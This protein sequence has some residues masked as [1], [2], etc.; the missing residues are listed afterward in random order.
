MKQMKETVESTLAPSI[1]IEEISVD[2]LQAPFALFRNGALFSINA[3]CEKLFHSSELMHRVAAHPKLQQTIRETMILKL[4]LTLDL[5]ID[6]HVYHCIATPIE[7]RPND[8][9]VLFEDI[10]MTAQREKDNALLYR[11]SLLFANIDQPLN[12]TLQ[13]IVEQILFEIESFDCSILLFDK[14]EGNLHTVA[15]G[16][17]DQSSSMN[18]EKRFALGEGVAGYVAI[19]KK[20]IVIPNIMQD[21]RFVKKVSDRDPLAL[22]CVPIVLSRELQGVICVTRKTN[23]G[24]SDREVQL[25]TII[26]GRLATL[27]KSAHDKKREAFAYDLSQILGMARNIFDDYP[28]VIETI[29]SIFCV[30]ACVIARCEG[31]GNLSFIRKESELGLTAKQVAI[32]RTLAKKDYFIKALQGRRGFELHTVL[33]A[34]VLERAKAT[35][36]LSTAIFP[37]TVR[38]QVYGF[39]CASNTRWDRTFSTAELSHGTTIATQMSAAIENTI[40]HGEILDER[41]RLQQIQE[42]LRDGLLLYTPDM[43]LAMYNTAAR[44]MLGFKRNVTGLEWSE[45]MNKNSEKYC[46]HLLQR[47]FDPEEFLRAALHDGK[48]STGLATLVG[49]PNRTV[50]VTVAPVYDRHGKISAILSHFRD[51]T[52]IHDLQTKM[53]VRLRQLTNLFKISSVSGFNTQHL[54]SRILELNLK[55]LSVSASELR[56][57]NTDDGSASI[58]ESVGDRALLDVL[59]PQLQRRIKSV[60]ETH[61]PCI[62]TLRRPNEVGVLIVPV[63]GHHDSCIG[64]LLVVNKADQQPFTK[65]DTHMLSIVAARIAS[66]LDTAWLLNQVEE[67]REKLAAIID[68][69]VDGILVTDA[70]GT[71]NIWNDA[72]EKMTGLSMNEVSGKPIEEVRTYFAIDQTLAAADGFSEILITHRKTGAKVW[73]GAAYAPIKSDD[74]LT[75][76]VVILRDIS[77]QK[78]LEIAKN[79]FVSTASHELR[80]PIT[81]IVGYLSMLRRGDAGKIINAQQAFFVDKAYS[82]A[83]RMVGIIEDILLTT[84]M[85]TGQM[86][87]HIEPVD[88]VSSIETIVGDLRFRAEEK[89]ISVVIDRSSRPMALAD[90]DAIQQVFNNIITNA[91]KYTPQEGKVT[92]GFTSELHDKRQ[93]LTVS[94]ADTGVG[95]EDNDQ[96]KI[97]DKF[98]RIDN[99]LSVSAGGTGLGLYI[100]KSSVEALGGKIWLESEKGKGSTFYV[101]LPIPEKIGKKGSHE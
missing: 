83:K 2:H 3:S 73:I 96:L 61:R 20:P 11:L 64:T 63:L 16:K 85:E 70:Q 32:L 75:G 28:K 97:F 92:I 53:A 26:A 12:K 18:G 35:K 42:T 45:V 68:Q 100:T 34:D 19:S 94:V 14:L 55:L 40:Y 37:I 36:C 44:R 80:S 10:S 56:L 93:Y 99:P 90:K 69:S 23:R 29:S 89:K 60:M 65:D 101:S 88:L 25:F 6:E 52:P 48:T 8:V 5:E 22:L 13:M 72:L 91:I 62:V 41:K 17:A 31:E 50:E 33:P 24:F 79:E 38:N 78:E 58:I 21:K 82:N 66:K 76:Y 4:R 95:I 71:I 9:G 43:K 57:I 81:A 51:I 67:D 47:H 98:A 7:N 74:V 77:R 27:I 86:R 39:V 1:S 59:T 84:R 87:Y 49:R 30:D 15:W 54:V 46:T